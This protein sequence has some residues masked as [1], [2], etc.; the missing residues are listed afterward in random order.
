[1]ESEEE[2]MGPGE[3]PAQEQAEGE[4]LI[5]R[6][7][8]RP[9]KGRAELVK[10]W[11]ERVRN[12]KVKHEKAFKRMTE[13]ME[14]VS[15]KQWNGSSDDKY[16]ANITQRLIAQ[17]VA[18][19]YAK[20]PKASAKRKKRL[21]FA[22]WTET[23][24]ELQN[25]QAM[26]AMAMQQG[27]PPDPQAVAMLQDVQQ[28]TQRRVMMDKIAR[29][30]EL[31]FEHVIGEQQPNFKAQMKQL[32][33][34]VC[35]TGVGYVKIGFERVT[36]R[37]PEDVEKIRDI[38]EQIS[39]IDRLRQ[40]I[41]DNEVPQD[42]EKAEQLKLM[43]HEL[44]EKKEIIVR[45]G[46]VFDFPPS[47]HIIIDPKCRHLSSLLG[48]DWIAHEFVLTPDDIK[49]IYKLDVGTDF[50][51]YNDDAMKAEEHC[52]DKCIVWEIYSKKDQMKY[53][54][55]DGYYDF[56]VDPECPWPELEGFWPIFPLVFNETENEKK[57]FPDSDVRLIR[58]VQVAYNRAR[59]GLREHR[60]SNRPAY[61]VPYGML[62]EKDK[63]NLSERPAHAIIELR[64]LQ[65]G[66]TVD[67]VIQ[68]IKPAAIDPALYD[69]S[70]LIDDS[71]RILGSQEANMGGTAASG[72][73]AT[74]V[75]VAESS[76]MSAVGSNVDD[77]D[78]F[79][80]ALCRAAGQVMLKEFSSEYVTKVVGPGAVWP[81]F[82][83]EEITEHIYLDI[84]A[85]SSG[86]PNRAQEIQN[87][88]RL[89]P[90]LM[91]TPGVPPEWFAKETLRRLDDRL[92]ASDIIIAGI[93]SIVAQNASQK[94][95]QGDIANDPNLQG[96][97]GADNQE[98][99]SAAPGAPG[100]QPTDNSTPPPMGMMG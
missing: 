96:A 44:N 21:D 24:A 3:N 60:H 13:D 59:E 56:A 40:D 17:R 85:G 49:E 1:M 69:T 67:S 74:E 43:L 80:G 32:I 31:M 82:S 29:T 33:R 79:L 64:G 100:P 93:P 76:R 97:Q 50:S 73:T 91:Q 39:A 10:T 37:R 54:V 6:N 16:V 86:R 15:G 22:V 61:A 71:L 58:P 38:S 20:N 57:L 47:T 95:M 94:A 41:A 53:V 46:I 84:E 30:L 81:Q 5:R 12:A 18:A 77:L 62:D 14:F 34:R 2:N 72:T 70:M 11:C 25:A 78:E 68:H 51:P 66:Q 42:S 19:L 8:P 9:D 28:G 36:E 55:I 23:M 83:G 99:T 92:E 65:P 98:K 45:E 90:V 35:V 88:E 75:S 26:A 4:G 87:W 7:L 63:D 27:L 89:A 52:D 48:A